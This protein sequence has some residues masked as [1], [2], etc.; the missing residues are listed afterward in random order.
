MICRIH[1][2]PVAFAMLGAAVL[3]VAIAAH[4]GLVLASV[5]RF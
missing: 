2:F 5:P 3:L 4:A 1:D